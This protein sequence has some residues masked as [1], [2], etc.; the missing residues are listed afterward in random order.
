MVE[1]NKIEFVCTA[2]HGRS[3]VA[4][5]IASNYL[6]EIGADEYRA[7]SS[8]SHVDVINSGDVSLDAMLH[9]INKAQE[10]GI[11]KSHD[12][13]ELLSAAMADAREDGGALGT[14]K[15]FYQLA[16]DIFFRE[17]HQYRDQ[18]LSSLGIEGELKQT[19]DQTIARPDTL[20]VFPM[21]EFNHQVAERI[22]CASDCRP[23]VIET[24]GISD[25]FGRDINTYQGSIEELVIVV[26]QK[27]DNPDLV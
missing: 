5:L 1:Q 27:I 10:R 6:K 23:Q 19:Q 20:A 17:E 3:P 15:N 21:S 16:A 24:L 13:L 2:N 14:L 11:Y 25:A 7:I 18:V 12:E 26:P 9:V 4:A 22:Y 8:G